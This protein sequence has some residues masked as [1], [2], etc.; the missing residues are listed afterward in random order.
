MLKLQFSILL[1]FFF[2]SYPV[3]GASDDLD[4]YR[5]LL[6]GKAGLN[7]QSLILKSTEPFIKNEIIINFDNKTY[8]VNNNINEMGMAIY[9]A[10]NRGQY[11]DVQR[12]LPYYQKLPEHDYLLVKF[13][14]AQLARIDRNYTK[15]ISDYQQILTLK[16]DFLRVELELARTYYEDKQN[17][18][19]LLLFKIILGKYAKQL[20]PNV[21]IV[22]G[23]FTT[24]L[25]KKSRWSGSFS[26]GYGYNSNINQVPNNDRKTCY[27]NLQ[28]HLCYGGSQADKGSKFIYDGDI[29]RSFA[30]YQHQS[31]QFKAYS[32]GSHY[33]GNAEYNENTTNIRLYYKYHDANKSLSIGP[34]TELKMVG[35]KRRYYG[36]G[37]GIDAEYRFSPQL[38]LSMM[39]DSKKMIYRTPYQSNDGNKS[40]LYLTGIYALTP[41][42][43]LFGGIDSSLVNKKYESDSY[44][45]YGARVGVFKDFNQGVNFLGLMSYKNTRFNDAQYEFNHKVRNDDEQLYLMKISIPKYSFMTLIPSISYKYRINNSSIDTLYS[46]KQSEVEFKLEKRF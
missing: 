24:E 13:A 10:L 33:E 16:P 12:I 6:K 36:I 27:Q 1:F 23:Q 30:L 44:Q 11:H 31:V 43:V 26:T 39:I 29:N 35:G 9:I 3:I 37:T 17:K 32:F 22:I 28:Q 42:T 7:N 34:I 40:N 5:F 14:E 8:K 20:P 46:Y 41:E 21:S 25:N 38:S 18:E 19:A 2:Y 45:Q 15:A 4:N